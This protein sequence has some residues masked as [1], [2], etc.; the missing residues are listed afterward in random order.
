MLEL[1][2]AS[3]HDWLSIGGELR[4]DHLD[5][6]DDVGGGFGWVGSVEDRTAY[7]EIRRAGGDGV[8]G[9]YDSRLIPCGR[10]GRADTRRYDGEAFAQFATQLFNFLGRGD[11]ASTAGVSGERTETQSL[12]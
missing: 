12:T 7:H 6:G 4:G 10:A 1:Y 3:L 5:F 2:L 8:G 9:S 11:Q